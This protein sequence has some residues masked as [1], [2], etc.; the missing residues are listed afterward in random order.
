MTP[1][2]LLAAHNIKLASTS[3]RPLLHAMPTMLSQ[4]QQGASEK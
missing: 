3:A 4:A 2:D 1:Q